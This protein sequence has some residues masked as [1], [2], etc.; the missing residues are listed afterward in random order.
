MP[1]FVQWDTRGTLNVELENCLQVPVEMPRKIDL[2]GLN[3]VDFE[4]FGDS[5]WIRSNFALDLLY[6]ALR[7]LDDHRCV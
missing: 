2:L 5:G 4:E 1:E 6:F 3:A 7:S